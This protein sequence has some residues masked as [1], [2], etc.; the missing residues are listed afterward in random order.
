MRVIHLGHV[1]IP[2]DHPDAGRLST[3]P[4]RWVLNHAVAQKRHTDLQVEVVAITHKATRD[5]VTDVE[6]VRVH[7]LRTFHPTQ[8]AASVAAFWSR[9]GDAIPAR[10][11][12]GGGTVPTALQCFDGAASF[13]ATT[14]VA[15]LPR[16]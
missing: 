9:G 12:H 6:G 14:G 3:H 4:G 13:S 16:S 8:R 11:E 7:F 5:F 2:L 15:R 1:P 10:V